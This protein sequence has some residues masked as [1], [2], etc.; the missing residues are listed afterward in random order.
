MVEKYKYPKII[1][2]KKFIDTRGYF[3]E[4]YSNKILKQNGIN[5]N[6]IQDNLSFSALH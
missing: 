3:S 1:K 4:I 2:I 5:E 6:F